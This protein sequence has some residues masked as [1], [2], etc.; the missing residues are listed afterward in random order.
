M[1]SWGLDVVGSGSS[2]RWEFWDIKSVQKESVHTHSDT[3]LFKSEARI[4]LVSDL[5]LP[6]LFGPIASH[7]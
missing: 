3:A 7:S 4:N 1:I 2:Y 5:S 6:P